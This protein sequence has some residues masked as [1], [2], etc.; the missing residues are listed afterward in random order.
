MNRFKLSLSIG[1]AV[2]ASLATGNVFGQIL[3]TYSDRDVLVAF[4]PTSANATAT[5][6]LLINAG[7]INTLISSSITANGPVTVGSASSIVGGSGVFSSLANVSYSAFAANREDSVNGV[8]NTLWV[9]RGTASP[10]SSAT[11]WNRQGSGTLGGTATKISSLGNAA[12]TY[13]SGNSGAAVADKT[14]QLPLAGNSSVGRW[15]GSGTSGGGATAN[16]NGTFQGN[17]EATFSGSTLRE[18]LF[19]IVP[20]SGQSTRVGAFQ[21]NSSGNLTFTASAVPEASTTAFAAVTGLGLV[22]FA[23]ARRKMAS[24]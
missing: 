14:I 19:M 17:S 12:V 22:G 8:I 15:I 23:I 6:S 9:T 10:S 7:N 2:L 24:K 5:S 18:D 4:R 3:F 1:A 13:L 20:G 11:P 21:L 16:F